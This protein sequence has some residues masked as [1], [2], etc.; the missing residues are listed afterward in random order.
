[1]QSFFNTSIIHTALLYSRHRRKLA[2][3]YHPDKNQD[4]IEWASK[5]FQDVA[6]AYEV[7]SDA[8]KRSI[9]DQ[10]GEEGL[11]AGAAGADP[12]GFPGG[13][14]GG[15]NGFPGGFP[16]GGRSRTTFHFGAGDAHRTFE[17]FFGSGSPGGA[18]LRSPPVR[19]TIRQCQ[20]LGLPSRVRRFVQRLKRFW[21]R[22]T[23]RGS[24]W[25]RDRSPGRDRDR[26]RGAL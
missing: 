2:L 10:F 9:Y 21:V 11:K 3:K 8:E 22:R 16:G 19:W 17:Q 7:L 12:G 1:M 14:G 15:F 13:Q 25:D 24:N 6:E 5:K 4:K 18:L 23:G 20:R 26:S